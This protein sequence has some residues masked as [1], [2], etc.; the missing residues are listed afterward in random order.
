MLTGSKLL[1]ELK[2]LDD[3]ALL[4]E[5]QLLESKVYHKLSNIPKSRLELSQ[6]LV[7]SMPLIGIF[8]FTLNMSTVSGTK[9]FLQTIHHSIITLLK[10][11]HALEKCDPVLHVYHF[12]NKFHLTGIS[13]FI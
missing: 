3:K 12:F 7:F 11:C 13:S 9:A 2:K 8:F 1:K 10:R 5:V 4:V 6:M